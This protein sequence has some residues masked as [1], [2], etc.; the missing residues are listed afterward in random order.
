MDPS[1]L[2]QQTR[3]AMTVKRVFG[4]PYERN[5]VTI[6]PVATIRGGAGGGQAGSSGGHLPGAG[7]TLSGT[8]LPSR[9]TS[10]TTSRPGSSSPRA[11]M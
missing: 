11:N 2:M 8:R 1:E 6:L 4:E 9:S 3:D 10:I 5:G 7:I